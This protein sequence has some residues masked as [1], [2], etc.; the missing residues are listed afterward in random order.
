LI[1]AELRA[2]RLRPRARKS[3]LLHCVI[4]NLFFE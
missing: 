2:R 1:A 3:E 4:A